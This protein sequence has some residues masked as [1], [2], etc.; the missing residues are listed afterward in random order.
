MGVAGSV[1]F[2]DQSAVAAAPATPAIGPQWIAFGP[3]PTTQMYVSWSMGTASGKVQPTVTPKVRWGPTTSYGSISPADSA[4]TVVLPTPPL[5]EPAENTVYF[6]LL[7]GGLAP[8]LTYHYS[9]SNDGVTWSADATF[10]TAMA[11]PTA[12]RFTAFGDQAANAA[13]AA[14]MVSLVSALRP[15]FHLVAGDLA[16]ATDVGIKYPDVTGFYPPQW[17][18]YLSMIG[19]LAA[20]SI[21]WMA[22][23]GAHEVEPLGADGYA[24]FITRFPQTYDL[25]S[26]SPVVHTFTYGNV[27]FI[28]LDG[29]DLS[30]QLTIN[31]GY[32]AGAQTAWLQNQLIRY[33]TAGSGIDFIVVVCNCSCYST[34]TNH[35]SDGGLRDAWGP[36]FDAYQVD[37]VISGHVHAYERTNPMIAASPTRHVPAGGSVNPVT[38]GTTYICAGGGGNGLYTSWYGTTD[39]GDAGSS[40][41]PKIWRW[42]GGDTPSGGSGKSVDVTDT[43]TGFS[44]VRRGVFHCLVVD[45]TPPSASNNQTTMFVQAVMPGQSATAVTSIT[46]PSTFDSVT[47]T[48]T[49]QALAVPTPTPDPSPSSPDPTQ[50]ST[51]PDPSPSSPDPT[52][53]S[54]APDPAPSSPDP[55]Q[56]STAPDPAPSSPD[57]TQSSTAPDPA[58]DPAPSSPSPYSASRARPTE[59]GWVELE[60]PLLRVITGGA[61]ALPEEHGV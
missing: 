52:Q 9:V 35:G 4:Q 2:H 31:T 45:V 1:L 24:G 26:G 58:P 14:P 43:S 42:S 48:R 3:D 38:D 29:N 40:T 8:G 13:T 47:L 56:S 49:S 60:A 46:A 23:V 44:A 34:N 17:E 5:S 30:A 36:L 25:T 61:A 10:S 32:S 59:S 11:G 16:Y 51:A 50:S 53:S 18:K 12:F 20:Q 6:H 19:P 54:T 27:A 28:H 55:T 33:R 39:A 15:A 41:P 22:S 21:P 37:L 57:P 7:I